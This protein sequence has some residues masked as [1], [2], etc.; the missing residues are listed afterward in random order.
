MEQSHALA[1]YFAG[2]PAQL[3]L[4]RALEA[5]IL[6]SCES[7]RVD[8]Q[9]SQITFR[10]PRVFACAS[11]PLRRGRDWPRECLLVTLGLAYR[12]DSPRVAV[13]TQPYPG[14]WTIHLPVAR[15]EEIDD[16]LLAW[17]REAYDF[18]RAKRR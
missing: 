11:L 12:L 17:V 7:V 6:A 16:E 10:C 5:R 2:K 9:A 18:A 8:V 1:A 3:T 4:Y 15:V 13:A 14:R